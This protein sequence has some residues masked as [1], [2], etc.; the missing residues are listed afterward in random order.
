MSYIFVEC[1]PD[2]LLVRKLGIPKKYIRHAGSKG[3]VCR[4]LEKSTGNI[5]LIDEDPE[6]PQPSYIKR[7]INAS[8]NLDRYHKFGIKVLRDERRDNLVIILSPRLEEWI[9]AST[10]ELKISIEYYGLP[11]DGN[12]LHQN[13]NIHL[14]KFEKLLGDLENRSERIK[15]LKDLLESFFSSKK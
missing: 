7:L 9:I 5:G 1:N 14:R 8:Q 10:K 15:I 3:N 2:E 11:S 4:K 6:S 12:R 13:I